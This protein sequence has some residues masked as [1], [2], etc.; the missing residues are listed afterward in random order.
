MTVS[1]R[2]TNRV[3]RYQ[4]QCL[5]KS[6][7]RTRWYQQL[8][9]VL[10]MVVPVRYR[11]FTQKLSIS[12]SQPFESSHVVISA[13]SVCRKYVSASEILASHELSVSVSHRPSLPHAL[14][15]AALVCRKHVAAGETQ[16]RVGCILTRSSLQMW[17]YQ[18]L[19]YVVNVLLPMRH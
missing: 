11:Q 15:S 6:G 19:W 2:D 3:A 13:A 18:R 1:V 17:W 12:A 5:A 14:V 16:V 4:S 9:H 10:K 7:F 8:W